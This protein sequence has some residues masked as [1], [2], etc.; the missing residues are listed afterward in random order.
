MKKREKVRKK[1]N[2]PVDHGQGGLK[3]K[4]IMS[5]IKSKLGGF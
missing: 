1:K 3:K 2:T 5:Q 4:I